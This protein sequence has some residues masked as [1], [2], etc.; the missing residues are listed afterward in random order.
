MED[1]DA[2]L[3]K[4]S[5]FLPE[6]MDRLEQDLVTEAFSLWEGFC[7]F[8]EQS[9]VVSAEKAA[10]VVLEPAVDRIEELKSRA[11]RLE[12]E[13]DAETVEQIREGLAEMW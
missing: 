3:K 2:K 9:M 11:E 5:E 8:C 12:I 7:A 10:T 6:L 1:L 13:A 4:Y